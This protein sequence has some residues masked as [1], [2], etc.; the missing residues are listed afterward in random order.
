MNGY[1]HW[2][3][4][5]VAWVAEP[6]GKLDAKEL[7]TSRKMK[8]DFNDIVIHRGYCYGFDD[9]IFGCLDLNEGAQKWAGGR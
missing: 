3:S 1:Q 5:N 2:A 4:F 6:G 7:W 8:P 9:A